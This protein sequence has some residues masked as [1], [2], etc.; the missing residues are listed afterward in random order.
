MFNPQQVLCLLLQGVVWYFGLLLGDKHQNLSQ[1]NGDRAIAAQPEL[2]VQLEVLRLVDEPCHRH[3]AAG[4]R[5]LGLE[6]PP[7]VAG[8]DRHLDVI[9]R[10]RV[11][12]AHAEDIGEGGNVGGEREVVVGYSQGQDRAIDRVVAKQAFASTGRGEEREGRRGFIFNNHA[13]H[14]VEENMNF[15]RVMSVMVSSERTC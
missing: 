6:E 10:H 7:L 15:N 14:A 13:L 4:G 2:Q 8:G 5:A 11:G 9:A 3:H 12:G 1:V